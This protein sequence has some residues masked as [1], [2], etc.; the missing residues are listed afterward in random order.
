MRTGLRLALCQMNA[1]V[2]DL[3]GNANRIRTGIDAAR[4]AGAELVLLP[5]LALTGYPPEDLLLREHFLDDTGAQLHELADAAKGIIAI[6]GFPERA[7]HGVYNSAA[8]LAGGRVHSVYRK[9]HLPNYGVFDEQRYFKSGEGGM[10]VDLDALLALHASDPTQGA[11][12]PSDGV[13]IEGVGIEGVGIEEAG[14][15]EVDVDGVGVMLGLTV[16]EDLWV[17][18]PPASEEAVAG[19][20]LIV[21]VSA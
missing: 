12:G 17:E 11:G 19:A 13:E 21:N 14:I 1:T 4:H 3:A 9:M 15:E 5:E 6:V 18:G 16:C 8:V 2:G 7:E 20:G 10:V